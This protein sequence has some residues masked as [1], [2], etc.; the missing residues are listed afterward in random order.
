LQDLVLLKPLTVP[1]WLEEAM[2]LVA[3]V[4]LGA[5]V[6]FAAAGGALLICRFDPFVPIFR[7][8]GSFGMLLAGGGLLGVGIF[9]G[10]PYC[11]ILCP[12]GA[13]LR[14]AGKVSKWRVT[15]TPDQCTRCQLCGNA[16]PFGAIREPVTVPARLHGMAADRRRLAGLLLL[17][18]VLLVGGGWLGSRLSVAAS[19]AVSQVALAEAYVRGSESPIPADSNSAIDLGRARAAQAPTETVTAAL[20]VRRRFGVGGWAFGAWVGLVLGAKLV[21]SAVGRHR[22]DFEPDRGRCVACARCFDFCPQERIRRGQLPDGAAVQALAGDRG[23]PV[24][25]GAG[26]GTVPQPVAMARR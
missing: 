13:L 10:R 16:C 14:L 9:F 2:G 21:Q 3:Y 7:R 15:I 22:T 12:Y 1:A 5:A 4:Y 23:V 19:R 18:P 25:T 11:R 8:T 20:E 6:W 24:Q 17:V 26:A